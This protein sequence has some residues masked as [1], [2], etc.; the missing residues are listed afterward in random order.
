MRYLAF[1]IKNFKGI[2]DIKFN[3]DD[4]PA[5]SILTLVGLN[6]S[7]KTTILEAL[8]YWYEN[9]IKTEEGL[10]KSS[11]A[12]AE[13]LVPRSMQYSFND[14]TEIVASIE[15]EISDRKHFDDWAKRYNYRIL[16]DKSESVIKDSV[17]HRFVNSNL[18]EKGTSNYLVQKL[19]L[20]NLKGRRKEAL[21]NPN[22]DKQMWIDL[23]NMVKKI[24][25]PIVYYPNF[26]FEFPNKIY[27]DRKETSD[28]RQNFYYRFLQDVLDSIDSNLTIEDS[29]LQRFRD[30]TGN[31][32]RALQST[33]NRMTSA[34]DTLMKDLDLFEFSKGG[35]RVI[36]NPP[37]EDK[38]GVFIEVQI[39]EGDDNYD[40]RERSLG[41]RWFFTFA[42]LTQFRIKR[43]GGMS[44]LFIFDEP[45]SNL[46]QTA[47][48][49]ILTALEKL[50]SDSDSSVIYATH[51]H[52]LISPKRL[53]TTYIVKNEGLDYREDDSYLSSMTDIKIYK[54][55]YF[56]SQYPSDI[57]YFQPILD[58]LE[59]RP[60]QLENVDNAVIM[61]GK[62]DFYTIAYMIKRDKNIFSIV[63][64]LSSTKLSSLISL[65]Y[66]WGKKFIILLDS[67]SAGQA[68]KARYIA[69]FG[70][71]VQNRIFTLSDVDSSWKKYTT[72]SLFSAD[73]KMLIQRIAFPESVK[74]EKSKFNTAIQELLINGQ[75][76]AISD[77]SIQKFAKIENFITEKLD[78]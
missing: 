71:I 22:T 31:N 14:K 74:F 63:P 38:E 15:I 65:Y 54:Y 19:I 40:I 76:L 17:V 45:A 20:E 61:E 59:Y 78:H 2:R 39:K 34:L 41:F 52:H 67:D 36:V 23:C 11:V 72:E 13:D 44:P 56:A 47:Q 77:E 9:S 57:D 32:P 75:Q 46:H 73:D 50:V 30:P 28:L 42:L 6:E 5:S 1:S 29:I 58:V 21:Y 43:S 27:I 69:D 35:R 60:S 51:S 25:Q 33:V 37:R 26:L 16:W 7:G 70:L 49:K 64:G 18:A 12:S 3:I 4:K 55:R 8:A 48:Q 53:E 10:H 24:I 62:N 68:Q 66:G